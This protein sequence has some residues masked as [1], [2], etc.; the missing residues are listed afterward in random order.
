MGGRDDGR[1]HDRVILVLILVLTVVLILVLVILSGIGNCSA[2][3]RVR[4]TED[5]PLVCQ[6]CAVRGA[7]LGVRAAQRDA[8]ERLLELIGGALVGVGFA[9]GDDL[10][11][12]GYQRGDARVG[13]GLAPGG[14]VLG[15]IHDLVGTRLSMQGTELH[16]LGIGVGDLV[17]AGFGMRRAAR[18]VVVV[19]IGGGRR[20]GGWRTRQHYGRTVG[21][22]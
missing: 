21:V 20:G 22:A 12:V 9:P 10:I 15:T 1:G 14:P 19:S 2:H 4:L 13:V 11:G 8:I 6:I 7:R 18:P 3:F 16:S 17:G 5:S